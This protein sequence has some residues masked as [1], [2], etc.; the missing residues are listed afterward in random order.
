MHVNLKSA[1]NLSISP[2]KNKKMLS[3][4]SLENKLNLNIQLNQLVYLAHSYDC[5]SL[6]LNLFNNIFKLINLHIHFVTSFQTPYSN[7][8]V[9]TC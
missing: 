3:F 9:Q 7:R 8:T 4:S 5:V 6:N 2:V 1:M